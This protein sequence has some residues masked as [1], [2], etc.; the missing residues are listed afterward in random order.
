MSTCVVHHGTSEWSCAAEVAIGGFYK[1][2]KYKIL[3]EI[4]KRKVC[5]N[6]SKNIIFEV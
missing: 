3:A 1:I 4:A 6:L 5:N 2:S